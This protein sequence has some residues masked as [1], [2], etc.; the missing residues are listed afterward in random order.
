[1]ADKLNMRHQ[2]GRPP[3][4]AAIQSPSKLNDAN[5]KPL[6]LKALQYAK[7]AGF[8]VSFEGQ[9][10]ADVESMPAMALG[11]VV[12][13]MTPDAQ[14]A[15]VSCGLSRGPPDQEIPDAAALSALLATCVGAPS[16]ASV[17]QQLR[18]WL[19]RHGGFDTS[20][21]KKQLCP[22]F[23]PKEKL[24]RPSGLD[25]EAF[26]STGQADGQAGAVPLSIKIKLQGATKTDVSDPTDQDVLVLRQSVERVVPLLQMYGYLNKAVSIASTG[27]CSWVV[28]ARR[29]PACLDNKGTVSIHRFPTAQ[30][31]SLWL[32]LCEQ[33]LPFF[34]TSDGPRLILALRG[35]GL[36]PAACR[37]L[38]EA[39]SSSRVYKVTP[40]TTFYTP[41][42]DRITCLAVVGHGEEVL[43]I[44]VVDDAKEFS[45]ECRVLELL[46]DTRVDF[47][48]L[49]YVPSGGNG[50]PSWFRGH[51]PNFSA[52]R[53]ID[54]IAG[55]WW[56]FEDPSK[57]LAD[58][59]GGCILMRCADRHLTSPTDMCAAVEGAVVGLRAAHLLHWCHCDL[60][61]G[62]I[63]HFSDSWQLADWGM[64]CPTD[65]RSIINSQTS[66]GRRAGTRVRELLRHSGSDQVTTVWTAQDDWEML[67]LMPYEE[68]ARSF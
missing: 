6:L 49:G 50:E 7:H 52:A 40:A 36:H 47:Y 31:G 8:A 62:N 41:S 39:K 43:A 5:A 12:S 11:Q 27:R 23:L 61:A 10:E 60:R 16:E 64:A 1:M 21:N 46:A 20:S 30:A 53:C 57:A 26:R 63:L 28:V 54:D 32:H 68:W 33:G 19:G 38:F 13:S 66:Q 3:A 14:R 44:K 55:T 48:A 45:N 58:I 67:A 42:S 24:S 9:P 34:L 51:P 59:D 37:V 18:L 17:Q 2:S 56:S 15:W 22:T 65:S 25:A 35:A 29:D 4:S